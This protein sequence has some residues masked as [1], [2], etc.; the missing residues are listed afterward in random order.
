M[1]INVNLKPEIEDREDF[2][3]TKRSD[4]GQIWYDYFL[5]GIKIYREKGRFH[6]IL[7]NLTESVPEILENLVEEISCYEQFPSTPRRTVG[8]YQYESAKAVLDKY[9]DRLE[10]RITGKTIEDVRDIYYRIRAGKIVP[11]ERWDEEQEICIVEKEEV[12]PEKE[13]VETKPPEKTSIV[14]ETD[15]SKFVFL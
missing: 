8:V 1:S 15:R 13:E 3:A 4:K 2:T 14:K 5:P 6:M 11:T 7:H 12:L 9:S 10:V